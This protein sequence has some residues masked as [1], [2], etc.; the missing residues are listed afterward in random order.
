VQVLECV[1][2]RRDQVPAL[3]AREQCAEDRRV[4]EREAAC[5]GPSGLVRGP[6]KSQNKDEEGDE[7]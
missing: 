7:G 1:Q 2:E 5:V 3:Q 4:L 6:N